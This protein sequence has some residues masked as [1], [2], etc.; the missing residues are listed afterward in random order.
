MKNKNA[1]LLIVYRNNNISLLLCHKLFKFSL[2]LRSVSSNDQINNDKDQVHP[3]YEQIFE[4]LHDPKQATDS[5]QPSI[6]YIEVEH[7]QKPKSQT[8]EIT[9]EPKPR[10]DKAAEYKKRKQEAIKR[11]GLNLF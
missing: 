7:V 9:I 11:L 8:P 3:T 4:D 10:P 1:Q 2:F 5:K 6:N